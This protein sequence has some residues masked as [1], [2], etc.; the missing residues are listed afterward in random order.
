MGKVQN[1]FATGLVNK[2]WEERYLPSDQFTDAENV[3]V[4]TAT[5]S[6]QGIAK[7][8]PGNLRKTF[9]NIQGAKAI[10][11]CVHESKN[12]IYWAVK[13]SFHDYIIEYDVVTDTPVIVLQSSTGT[14]LNF[15][16]GERVLNMDIITD[17][18]AG[19]DLL[20]WSG[21]SNEPRI[22]NIERSKTFGVNGFTESEIK[23]IKAPP[24]YP[25][26]LTP[27]RSILNSESNNLQDR[28]ISFCY[29][30]KY[31]DGYYSAISSWSRY[32]FI[33]GN[34]DL[35]FDT[36]ENFGM[37][38]TF[39]AVDL[40]FNTGER[41]VVQVD[42][43]FKYSNSDTP[44]LIDRF[45][46]ADE[47]WADNTVQS[48]LFDNSKVYTVL[49]T[50]E[51]YRSFDNV[52]IQTVAQTIAGNRM[53]YANYLEGRDLID[54]NGDPVIID[55]T[56]DLVAKKIVNT[57]LDQTISSAT[58]SYEGAPVVIN[59]AIITVSFLDEDGNPISLIEGAAIFV[60]FSILSNTENIFFE[61]EFSYYLDADY[62]DLSDLYT[63]SNFVAVLAQ[64]SQYFE[65]NGGIVP[66][67]DT[68]V[69]TVLQPF[70]ATVSGNNLIISLPVIKYEINDG[71]NPVSYVYDYFQ[72]QNTFSYF[73]NIGVGSSLKSR[74]SYEICMIYRDLE[75][76]KT[77]ALT[78]TNN[79][80]FIPNLNCI[81]QNQ[82]KVT[83]P[84]AQKPPVWA[85]T[86]KFGIKVNK[87]VYEQIMASI[88]F[89]DDNYRW[90]KLEGENK[91][92]VNDGDILVV[93]KD[94]GGPLTDVVKVK[95]LDKQ[96][97]PTIQGVQRI[98]SF[99]KIKPTAFDIDYDVDEFL[100]YSAY[101]TYRRNALP[102]IFLG[103]LQKYNINTF[104]Y[105]DIPI[106]QG[107]KITLTLTFKNGIFQSLIPDSRFKKIY[108]VQ[109]NYPSFE[110][111]FNSEVTLPLQS[112]LGGAIYT[113]V[114]FIT[115]T[116]GN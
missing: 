68:V 83:I 51:Y 19:G 54:A 66:P 72:E 32:F 73:Q 41:E 36:F 79:T 59:D 42:L 85:T 91:N 47:G 44:Y 12:K 102:Q 63:N 18:E 35:D 39:N 81:Y 16:T 29:R 31:K 4:A 52:P 50:S 1:V 107:S 92:K 115:G 67:D 99:F 25:P 86:Y 113:N 6:S 45:V 89:K 110:S 105:D 96:T 24:T 43:I 9:L 106:G 37:L 53:M 114:A 22:A 57:V 97:N 95:V 98:G 74:R 3:I 58:Y 84:G 34:F 82:I 90:V 62:A 70:G 65:A 49:P 14:R 103:G 46:K 11:Q 7:N 61:S 108:T 10:G 104:S 71:I 55:F 109:N 20:A 21:D 26:I 8:V 15:K 17:G 38:N 87:G 48:L 77:T 40:S 116:D 33:P 94:S 28:F 93:K 5:N 2:D 23:V 111:W 13:G 75:C 69:T 78:S 80:Y 88:Y 27:V 101:S 64:F 112:Q 76:R 100:N 56:L 30:Y 60:S